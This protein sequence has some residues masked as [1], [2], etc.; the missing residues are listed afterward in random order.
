M[1]W[2]RW[3]KHPFRR[4][5][6]PQPRSTVETADSTASPSVAKEMRKILSNWKLDEDVQ[7]AE[8]LLSNYVV[9]RR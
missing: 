6:T 8:Q 4:E 3:E 2:F 7:S 5:D 9:P 1:S